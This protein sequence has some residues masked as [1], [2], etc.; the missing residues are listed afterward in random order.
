M[1]VESDAAPITKSLSKSVYPVGNIPNCFTEQMAILCACF[2]GKSY[3]EPPV[4]LVY[5]LLIDELDEFS[6]KGFLWAEGEQKLIEIV[7]AGGDAP[8]LQKLAN[9]MTSGYR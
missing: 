6:R 7:A 5:K 2:A 4:H 9:Q 1:I 8:E 3:D